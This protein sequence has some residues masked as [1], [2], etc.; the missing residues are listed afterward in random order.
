[1]LRGEFETLFAKRSVRPA[2]RPAASRSRVLV[3]S[4]EHCPF[5]AKFN[6][7]KAAPSD[8]LFGPFSGPAFA[9]SLLRFIFPDIQDR[10]AEPPFLRSL[11][12]FAATV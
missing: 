9:P 6:P 12:S 11:R 7:A 8:E 4:T 5:E 3:T 2:A 10:K 1:M